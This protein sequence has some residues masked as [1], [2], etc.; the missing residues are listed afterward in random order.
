MA[1]QVIERAL[2]SFGGSHEH[3][4]IEIEDEGGPPGIVG[5]LRDELLEDAR[6]DVLE[7]AGGLLLRLASGAGEQCADVV[8][9]ILEVEAHR[10][11]RCEPR[12]AAVVRV[13]DDVEQAEA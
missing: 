3:A 8:L 12:V 5:V 10:P 13:V 2:G 1:G 9:V 7:D 6:P 11:Q 4:A